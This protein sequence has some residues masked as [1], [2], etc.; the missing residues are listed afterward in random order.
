MDFMNVGIY[1]LGGKLGCFARL[2]MSFYCTKFKL[3]GRFLA[4]SFYLGV[5]SLERGGNNK[6]NY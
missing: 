5:K 1:V 4:K 6:W 3:F 2:E